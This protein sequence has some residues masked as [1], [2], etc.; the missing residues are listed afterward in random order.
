MAYLVPR[1]AIIAFG[2]FLVWLG[3]RT[4]RALVNPFGPPGTGSERASVFWRVLTV[5]TGIAIAL[6]GAVSSI[7]FLLHH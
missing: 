7:V 2:L 4:P 3:P 1:L 6:D 5:I